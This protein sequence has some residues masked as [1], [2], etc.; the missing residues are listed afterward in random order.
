MNREEISKEILDFLAENNWLSIGPEEN[1]KKV[2]E[3]YLDHYRNELLIDEAD[4]QTIKHTNSTPYYSLTYTHLPTGISVH[5]DRCRSYFKDDIPLWKE[6][7]E[8]VR[9][10]AIPEEKE[11]LPP[12]GLSEE[13]KKSR[14]ID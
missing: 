6:L 3:V 4:V 1:A 5:K 12:C 2:V 10:G 9:M 14:N 13:F 11:E 7:E 8:R